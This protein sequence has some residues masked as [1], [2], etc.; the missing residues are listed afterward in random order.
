MAYSISKQ[1]KIEIEKAILALQREQVIAYPTESMYGLGCDIYSQDALLRIIK[2][3]KRD[4]SKGLIVVAANWQQ[5][6]NLT[7]KLPESDYREIF[8]TWPGATTWVFPAKS[9]VPQLVTGS[10]K[11]I[12][13]RISSNPF[14]Q[15]LCKGFKGP[16]ISTSANIQGHPPAISMQETFAVFGN[17]IDCYVPGKIGENKKASKI[18]DA[19]TKIVLRK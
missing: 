17:K 6:E 5:V 8:N 1:E 12:A 2:L 9:E 11:T 7:E 19:Q 14:V 16:I 13:I 10:K 15:E 3:K 18:I 4:A